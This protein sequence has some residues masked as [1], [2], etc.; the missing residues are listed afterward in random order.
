MLVEDMHSKALNRRPAQLREYIQDAVLSTPHKGAV[1]LPWA[2]IRRE[3]DLWWLRA[4]LVATIVCL[5]YHFGPQ[6]SG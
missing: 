3:R 5:T 6:A 1:R 4:S 2:V